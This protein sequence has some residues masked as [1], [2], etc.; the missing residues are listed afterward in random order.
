[1][2][3]SVHPRSE[4]LTSPRGGVW[5]ELFKCKYPHSGIHAFGNSA[6]F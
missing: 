3:S 4:A 6:P 5:R 2:L 1:M